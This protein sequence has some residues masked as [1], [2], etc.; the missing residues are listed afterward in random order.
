MTSAIWALAYDILNDDR[1]SYLDWFHRIHIP[2]KLNRP[3]YRWAAHFEGSTTTPNTYSYIALFGGISTR[4]F[5]DPSPAQLKIKQDDLTRGMMARRRNPFA[6]ILAHEWSDRS[7]PSTSNDDAISADA[8]NS[9]W[10][11]F[12]VIDAAGQ[13][14]NIGAWAVQNLLPK[15]QKNKLDAAKNGVITRKF[16]SVTGAPAHILF[17]ETN[18]TGLADDTTAAA[19]RIDS[20]ALILSDMPETTSLCHRSGKRIWPA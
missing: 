4:I 5:L 7:T 1:Q 3:G 10:L 16:I 17:H 2:E 14:E 18:R 13:G 6:T 12:L 8:I 9:D 19:S 11:D 20:E 15:L